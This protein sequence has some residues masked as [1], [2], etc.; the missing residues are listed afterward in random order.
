M[1][2]LFPQPTILFVFINWRVSVDESG[3]YICRLTFDLCQGQRWRFRQELRP[4]LSQ[5]PTYSHSAKSRPFCWRQKPDTT[6]NFISSRHAT[7]R[8]G[9]KKGGE[10][11]NIWDFLPR[12]TSV[13]LSLPLSCHSLLTCLCK[14]SLSWL[15]DKWGSRGL[16]VITLAIKQAGHYIS[17][18]WMDLQLQRVQASLC[19]DRGGGQARFGYVCLV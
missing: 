7:Q 2:P 17:K 15:F 18:H 5:I 6:L 11:D 12:L 4:A 3:K 8:K 13:S 10:K 19:S 9:E 1:W 16:M 14:P